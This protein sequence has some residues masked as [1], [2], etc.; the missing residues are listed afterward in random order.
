[1]D[2]I[3]CDVL[4]VGAGPAGCAAARSA[5][6][7]GAKTIFID[8]KKEVG[9]PVLCGEGIG[10][11]LFSYLP[12]KIPK[13]QLIWK[14]DGLFF[15]AEDISVEKVGG[16]WN[17]Y[18]VDRSKFDKWLSSLA[19]QQGADLWVN[20]ELVGLDLDGDG[21]V[22]KAVVIRGGEEIEIIP[23]VVIAADG[24]ES[25]VLKILGLYTPERGY[26]AEVYSWEMKNLELFNPY[27]EQ[28]YLGDFT[29]SGYAY[30]FPKSKKV[31]NVG[32]GGIYPEKKLEQY[33]N[34]FLEVTHV[35]KQVKNAEYVIEKTKKTPWRNIQD[36]WII[37]NTI[38]AGD[39]ANQTFKPLGEGI[40]PSIIGGDLAGYF[41]VKMLDVKHFT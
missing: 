32:V 18:S 9:V 2:K 30:I 12:F 41:S 31:A 16:Y 33:F 20:T 14:I 38:F 26:L 36:D 11:Y 25:T 37:G 39:A 7:N 4:V 3:K 34:E 8:K 1:M 10:E 6:K 29:P 28:I 22:K 5:A 40:L 17:G 15:W 27:L 19:I 35:K 24:C 21:N 13:D 23:R